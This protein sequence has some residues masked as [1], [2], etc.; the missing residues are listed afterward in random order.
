M[1][2]NAAVVASIILG[3]LLG[4]TALVEQCQAAVIGHVIALNPGV[5]VE[6]NGNTLPLALKDP[7]ELHDVVQSDA[8][9]KVQIILSDDTALSM[10]ANS[11]LDMREFA[12]SGSDSRFNVHLGQG[13]ARIITGKIVEQNPQGFN[14][15]TPEAT[16]GIRGTVLAVRSDQGSTTVFVE[17]TLH[18]QV[19]VNNTQVPQGFKAVVDSLD[20]VP[21][22][23]PISPQEQQTIEQESQ[24]A[25]TPSS[26][27]LLAA[28]AAPQGPDTTLGDANLGQQELGDALAPPKPTTAVV[29]G[30]LR[31]WG[32]AGET[33]GTFSFDVALS[34]G[35]ISNASMS[36]SKPVA[37][38]SNL[39]IS[40][41]AL[42][43]G[44]GS[45]GNAA[46][47]MTEITGYT[48]TRLVDGNS[49]VI[50]NSN[51]TFAQM[52]FTAADSQV[53][54]SGSGSLGS[55]SLYWVNGGGAGVSGNVSGGTVSLQP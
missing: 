53:I 55:S 20:A 30:T 41:F 36:G 14:V 46:S 25:S 29:S 52:R 45:I 26:E 28:Y 16:V 49:V 42:H 21:T 10:G 39:D 54:A 34:S 12:D 9:G 7:I 37:G 50:P 40:E 38:L 31:E 11:R 8:T 1:R 32:L 47:G 6:R 33:R 51:L 43:G 48:A 3:L 44:S 2:K 27:T 4:M 24:V 23:Q 13:L 19:F 18:R 22:P 17:N 35:S 5:S 15:T